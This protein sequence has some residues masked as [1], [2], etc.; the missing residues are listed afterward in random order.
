MTVHPKNIPKLGNC[1]CSMVVAFPVYLYKTGTL[2]TCVV[3]ML[4]MF[5]FELWLW[6]QPWKWKFSVLTWWKS[7]P[8]WGFICNHSL[9]C[10]VPV[11]SSN[12]TPGK[13]VQGSNSWVGP[14]FLCWWSL[15]DQIV[16]W[17]WILCH[18]I[19]NTQKNE[20]QGEQEL[21]QC[22]FSKILVLTWVSGLCCTTLLEQNSNWVLFN[23]SRR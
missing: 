19:G 5:V 16:P 3:A 11:R 9:L 2:K 4:S 12:K 1:G 22:I 18:W 10:Q 23:V 7:E 15:A 21:N 6:T 8:W 17:G 20:I 13:R 14:A